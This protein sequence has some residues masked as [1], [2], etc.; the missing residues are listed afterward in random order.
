MFETERNSSKR[1]AKFSK[2]KI[3]SLKRRETSKDKKHISSGTKRGKLEKNESISSG[4]KRGK[5]QERPR[6]KLNTK[7]KG[8]GNLVR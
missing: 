8:M 2:E 7:S 1:Y 5:Y 6:S 3:S 4:K